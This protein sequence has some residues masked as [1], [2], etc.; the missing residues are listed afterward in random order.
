MVSEVTLALTLLITAALM[1]ESF[2]RLQ[3]VD[4]GFKARRVLTTQLDLPESVYATPAQ[5][6]QFYDNALARIA[7]VPGVVSVAVIDHVPMGG[8]NYSGSVGVEGSAETGEW[9]FAM[10]RSASSDYFRTLGIPLLEGRSFSVRDTAAAH[11]VVIVN[12]VMAKHFWPTGSA[13]GKRLKR[14]GLDSGNP[15]LEVVGV[16]GD[17]KHWGLAD[18]PSP[19]IYQPIAQWP[20]R[21]GTLVIRT[22]SERST[23]VAQAVRKAVLAVDPHQPLAEF[24]T[25]TR[26][27]DNSM[28]LQSMSIVL[29]GF[30]GTIALLIG[31]AGVFSVIYYLTLQRT[32]EF[33]IRMALGASPGNIVQLVLKQGIRLVGVGLLIGVALAFGVARAMAGLLYGIGPGDL[34]AYASAA[35]LLGAIA[36][37][38]I[39]LPA[40]QVSRVAPSVSTRY[41]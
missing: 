1:L 35:L 4:P 3:Q 27:V 8:S 29:L 20:Q 5:I 40:R 22:A 18:G 34:S 38:A 36:A 2:G 13:L 16:A 25:L 28:L 33:G 31:A 12:Q 26:L 37:L 11:P 6:T 23:S 10:M 32:H 30:F 39:Y 7:S 15:W 17:V 14:D 41:R 21:S 24:R 19:Q 9:S